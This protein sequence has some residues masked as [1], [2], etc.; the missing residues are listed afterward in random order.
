MW[1]T[2][3]FFFRGLATLLLWGVVEWVALA[4]SR[5]LLRRRYSLTDPVMPDT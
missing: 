2:N 3:F 4:R 5:R 1:R